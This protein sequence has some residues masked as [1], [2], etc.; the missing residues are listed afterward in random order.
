[1][2]RKWLYFP[3]K[4]I[5]K[6]TSMPQ[7]KQRY[8]EKYGEQLTVAFKG[9]ALGAIKDDEML[10]IA[11][12][13]LPNLAEI[14]VTAYEGP[15][16]AAWI[17]QKPTQITTTANDLADELVAAKLPLTHKYIKIITCG[18]AGMVSV[19]DGKATVADGKVTA[20][21]VVLHTHETDCLG[22]VLAKALG[23]KGYAGIMVK[24]YPGFVNA[25]GAKKSVSVEGISPASQEKNK[26]LFGGAKSEARL[27][28]P[29][30]RDGK[31]GMVP[32]PTKLLND[33]WFDR[34]GELKRQHI[35]L[36]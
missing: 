13:G 28:S 30:W 4:D 23:Q 25:T 20:I 24:A 17:L 34:T 36:K 32:V 18:G 27:G 11:G 33:F 1:M 19:N 6:D 7:N 22:S 29:Y 15:A 26:G 12:H 14:G 9:D 31:I 10:I 3:F 5:S 2:A 8:E 16:I 35:S 21:D